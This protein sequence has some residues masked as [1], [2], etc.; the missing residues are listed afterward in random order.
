MLNRKQGFTLVELVVFIAVLGILA[1]IAVPMYIDAR[2]S[3]CGSRVIADLHASEAAVN[4][5]YARNGFFP[6][7]SDALV[8][9]HLAV[10][11]IPPSG[12]ATIKK[13]NGTSLTLE[14]Q[15]T[16]YVYNKPADYSELTVKIGRVTIGGMTIEDLL[17]T[18]STSL[19]L[20]DG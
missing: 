17:S 11:P 18:T 6:E 20:T 15:A 5:F 16:R 8:G 1:S 4:I 14:V 3:A 12:K 10:W 9:T 2:A 7:D 13:H 19:T